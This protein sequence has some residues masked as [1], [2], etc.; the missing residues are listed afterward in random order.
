MLKNNPKEEVRLELTIGDKDSE[1][2]M[3]LKRIIETTSH[4]LPIKK[5]KH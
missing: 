1:M 5:T 3:K 4:K 2:V